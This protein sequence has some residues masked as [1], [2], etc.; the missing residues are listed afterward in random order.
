MGILLFIVFGF[1]VGLLARAIMPGDQKMG[2]AMTTIL[3]VVGSFI[4]GFLGSLISHN[5]VTSFHP[6][7][8]IGSV[9]GALALLFVGGGLLRNRVHA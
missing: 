7:G 2:I 3:G 5:E 8:L 9:I 4:G 1:I 6:A